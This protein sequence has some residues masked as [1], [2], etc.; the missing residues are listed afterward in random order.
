MLQILEETSTHVRVHWKGWKGY[1]CWINKK[2]AVDRTVDE[3]V[4]EA[5][6]R[7]TTLYRKFAQK[8]KRNLGLDLGPI[9][10]TFCFSDQR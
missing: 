2:D 5:E 3:A 4:D 8:S 1:D 6:Q 9:S 10:L 7:Q